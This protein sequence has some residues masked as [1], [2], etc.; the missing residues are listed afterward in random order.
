MAAE[1]YGEFSFHPVVFSNQYGL[2]GNDPVEISGIE[3]GNRIFIVQI[4]ETRIRVYKNRIASFELPQIGSDKIKLE[5]SFPHYIFR[6]NHFIQ[7]KIQYRRC[8]IVV[9]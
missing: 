5:R 6:I 8:F 7:E 3:G 2:Q 1:K 9:C 4:G